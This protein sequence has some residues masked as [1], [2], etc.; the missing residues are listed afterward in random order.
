MQFT[1][2]TEIADKSVVMSSYRQTEIIPQSAGWD[3]IAVQ[4]LGNGS[5][6][7]ITEKQSDG[8]GVLCEKCTDKLWS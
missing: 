5:I 7:W 4:S 1:G 3:A 6:N 2:D 8:V